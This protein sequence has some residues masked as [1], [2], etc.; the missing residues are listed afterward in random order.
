LSADNSRFSAASARSSG[1]SGAA[2]AH[3]KQATPNPWH[4]MCTEL[5]HFTDPRSGL[6]PLRLDHLHVA[7]AHLFV[8]IHAAP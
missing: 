7:I 3:P 8:S 6:W 5:E 1:R 2:Q 4:R